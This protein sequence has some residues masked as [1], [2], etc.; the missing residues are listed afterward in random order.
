MA[1]RFAL[2]L[3]VY[4]LMIKFMYLFIFAVFFLTNSHLTAAH[5][6]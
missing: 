6:H 2:G 5:M 4:T 1:V 3:E